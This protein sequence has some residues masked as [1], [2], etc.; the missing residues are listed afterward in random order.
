MKSHTLDKA[1]LDALAFVRAA[2]KLRAVLKAERKKR[3]P[4][5]S[6]AMQ[7]SSMELTR[8]LADL[9]QGR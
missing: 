5:E 6:G 2:R 8:R 3:H 9:R 4:L 1:I 7:R